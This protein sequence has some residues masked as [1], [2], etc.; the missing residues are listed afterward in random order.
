[1]T[2][3]PARGG[4][5]RHRIA[6]GGDSAG[7]YLSAVVALKAAEAAATRLNKSGGGEAL[8]IGGEA[9]LRLSPLECRSADAESIPRGIDSLLQSAKAKARWVQIEPQPHRHGKQAEDL[10][11]IDA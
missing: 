5:R 7:G 2:T 4:S 11:R 8:G 3:R 9:V 10:V 6:V 1:M